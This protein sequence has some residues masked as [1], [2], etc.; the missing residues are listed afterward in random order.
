MEQTWAMIHA[1]IRKVPLQKCRQTRERMK[2]GASKLARSA[3]ASPAEVAPSKQPGSECCVRPEATPNAGVEG[4]ITRKLDIIGQR[5][6][7]RLSQFKKI[8]AAGH[9]LVYPKCTCGCTVLA[10]LLQQLTAAVK[11]RNQLV[12]GMRVR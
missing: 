10:G 1:S 12:H 2:K 7:V 5:C 3:V 8:E 9:A 6:E 4:H 11:L